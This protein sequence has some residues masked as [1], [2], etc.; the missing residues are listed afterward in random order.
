VPGVPRDSARVGVAAV[1]Q[2]AGR[3][4]VHVRSAGRCRAGRERLA[5]Q[6]VREAVA[7][8]ALDEQRRRGRPL[9]VGQQRDDGP[10]EHVREQVEVDAGA[11]RRGR[12]ER[13]RH[14]HAERVGAPYHRVADGLR[15]QVDRPGQLG[16][17]QRVA[18]AAL[19]QLGGAAG[20]DD[21]F[22]SGDVQRPERDDLSVGQPG[23]AGQPRRQHGR[24]AAPEGERQ[25]RDRR[26]VR[27]VDVV[28]DDEQRRAG[29]GALAGGQQPGEQPRL[30]RRAVRQRDRGRG[31]R[32][33][34]GQGEERGERR[35]VGPEHVA[36]GGRPA[37]AQQRGQPVEHR[38]QRQVVAEH[39][40]GAAQHG[41]PAC[42][43]VRDHRV[44]QHG[45]ADA[46]LALDGDRATR[47]ERGRD[48]GQLLVAAGERRGLRRR[49]ARRTGDDLAAEDR[50]VQL[51]GGRRRVGTQVLGELLA[52]PGVRRQRRRRSAG[53][54]VCA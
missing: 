50:G 7:G 16:E 5:Y 11:E 25:P 22:G 42:R 33:C 43:R 35:G 37:L 45:L 17:E 28:D 8:T 29:G 31:E 14:G 32:R 19:V 24:R 40:G 38:L 34:A 53:G 2:Y 3:R 51:L 48:R 23:A 10:V 1:G 15:Q 12:L 4:P 20:A 46:G 26:G 13:L 30:P 36:G 6:V 41:A 39:V 54:D 47:G 21:A 9:R 44:E 27:D 52:R 49:C 18:A